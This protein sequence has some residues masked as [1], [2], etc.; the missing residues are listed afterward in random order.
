[1]AK[2][3]RQS[4][5]VALL[6]DGH[7]A[8]R[9]TTDKRISVYDVITAATG[10]KNPWRVWLE[11]KHAFPE[12]LRFTSDFKFPGQGQ[13][14]TPVMTKH[15]F[16]KLTMVMPGEQGKHFR[17]QYADIILRYLEGDPTLAEEVIDRTEDP[18]ALERIV[19]RAKTKVVRQVFTK[20]LKTYGAIV[21]G[22]LVNTYAQCTGMLNMAATG[23]H[24]KAI[25][26]Y[27]GVRRTRDAVP[28]VYLT[29]LMTGEEL[30]TANIQKRQAVGHTA[31]CEATAEVA[32]DLT[33]LRQKYGIPDWPED[34][35]V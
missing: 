19:L 18:D 23:H 35:I 10:S 29:L 28:P 26:D 14:P 4:L 20:T 30:T 9:M 33:Q 1:M 8:I 27:T 34:H 6:P 13:K 21:E 31:L 17:E 12:V 3:Y 2:K 25:Q 32:Y 22:P 7:G 11:I 5:P 24:S 15:G 16:V